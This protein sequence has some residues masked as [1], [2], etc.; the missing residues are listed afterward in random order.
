M[1]SSK[2]RLKIV[3]YLK[4]Y[5]NITKIKPLKIN[6]LINT[7]SSFLNLTIRQRSPF[8]PKNN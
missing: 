5:T 6:E 2:F 3:Y 7:I 1:K 8:S 4:Y